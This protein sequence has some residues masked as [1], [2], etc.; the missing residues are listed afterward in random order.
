M[1]CPSHVSWGPCHVRAALVPYGWLS[2]MSDV[3]LGLWA[4]H[5]LLTYSS[6]SRG[7]PTHGQAHRTRR[8][9][10]PQKTPGQVVVAAWCCS[11]PLCGQGCVACCQGFAQ[12]RR[13]GGSGCCISCCWLLG[14][15]GG[16]GGL[17]AGVS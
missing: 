14:S 2:T 1:N 11:L 13:A 12:W 16:V 3:S 4:S 5:G 7:A 8:A 10:L 6:A 15:W 17:W 9:A